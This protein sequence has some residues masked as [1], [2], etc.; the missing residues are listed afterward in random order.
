[1]HA[2]RCKDRLQDMPCWDLIL[3]LMVADLAF[4]PMNSYLLTQLLVKRG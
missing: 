4:A 3:L 1:M 2:R